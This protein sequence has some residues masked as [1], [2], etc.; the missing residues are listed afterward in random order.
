MYELIFSDKAKRFLQKL[1]KPIQERIIKALER[2]I[3]RPEAYL[4]KLIG[5]PLYKFRVG[6]Y[7]LI[8][9]VDK[10]RIIL[11]VMKIGHRKNVYN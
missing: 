9:E 5:E 2:I 1:D 4:T 6:N 7:R 10:V 8:I 11:L 3:I